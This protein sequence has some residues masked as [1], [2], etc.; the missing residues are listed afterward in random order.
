MQVK[1]I[2]FNPL[3][4][5][6]LRPTYCSSMILA[7]SIHATHMG[8]DHCAIINCFLRFYF[9][10]CNPCELRLGLA[11][12]HVPHSTLQ[13]MQPMR[14]ATQFQWQQGYCL[15]S[16]SIHATHTGCDFGSTLLS[17]TVNFNPCNLCWL[18]NLW[19]N[20]TTSYTSLQST[21]PVR[22]ESDIKTYV[23]S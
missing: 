22:V 2:H 18:Q 4:P 8:C 6:G 19:Q 5:C 14:I 3:S 9:N 13:S 1:T 12:S 15:C 23:W 20:S 11:I 21:Q 17:R 10:P 7:T 16:T